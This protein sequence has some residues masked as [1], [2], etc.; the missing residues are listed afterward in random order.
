VNIEGGEAIV[1]YLLPLIKKQQ[2]ILQPLL[3]NHPALV[4]QFGVSKLITIRLI[5]QHTEQSVKV[6]S[7]ILEVPHFRCFN[8]ITPFYIE[9][10]FGEVL[11]KNELRYNAH[12]Q[13]VL[14]VKECKGGFILPCWSQVLDIASRAHAELADIQTLGWDFAITADGPK[15]I[16]GNIN[17]GVSV[18]QLS[19]NA[20]FSH[21]N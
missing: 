21:F 17:W 12:A 7:A 4:E 14:P 8:V 3:E 19:G 5:T 6:I 20:C 15:L 10:E 18:H 16:E 9:L 2:Y 13:S 11:T 1:S